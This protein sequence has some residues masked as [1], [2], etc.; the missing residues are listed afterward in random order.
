MRY[1]NVAFKQDVFITSSNESLS[2]G[3]IETVKKVVN[4]CFNRLN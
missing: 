4:S 3:K 1:S 2:N